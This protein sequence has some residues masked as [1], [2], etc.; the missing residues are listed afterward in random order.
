[1][2]LHGSQQTVKSILRSDYWRALVPYLTVEGR[3]GDGTL[4]ATH[5][6]LPAFN[7]QEKAAMHE[8]MLQDGYFDFQTGLIG[9]VNRLETAFV[10]LE[11]QGWSPIWCFVFDEVWSLA[12]ACESLLQQTIHPG[13]RLNHDFFAWLLPEDGSGKGWEPHRDRYSMPFDPDAVPPSQRGT[14]SMVSQGPLVQPELRCPLP[15]GAT[16]HS[17]EQS[18][19]PRR[20]PD[21]CWGSRDSPILTPEPPAGLLLARERSDESRWPPGV[22]S[23][24]P[25]GGG[26][27]G[28]PM[29][30][31]LW[32][33]VTAASPRSSCIYVVPAAW[34]THYWESGSEES[35][36]DPQDVRALPVP[37]GT[38]IV[39][40]GRLLHW[41][42]RAAGRGA[43]RRMSLAFAA[44]VP[45][46]EDPGL[47]L[48]VPREA[49]RAA[50]VPPS[51]EAGH[52][53]PASDADAGGARGG[54][55]RSRACADVDAA[56]DSEQDGP[57]G[58]RDEDLGAE[59]C[60]PEPAAAD[61]SVSAWARL[62]D[63]SSDA[64]PVK[65]RRLAGD[66]GPA[67]VDRGLEGGAT[68]VCSTPLGTDGAPG[69]RGRDGC[70]TLVGTVGARGDSGLAGCTTPVGTDGERGDRGLEGCATRLG[71][72]GER[73]DRG[74]AGWATCVGTDGARGDR[75]LEG[76]AARGGPDGARGDRGLEGCATCVGGRGETKMWCDCSH[77]CLGVQ[78]GREPPSLREESVSHVSGEGVLED[79]ALQGRMPSLRQRIHVIFTQLCTYSEREPVPPFV[80][81][82]LEE[83][84]GQGEEQPSSGAKKER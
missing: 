65:A 15:A 64:R 22:P 9:L 41:G 24:L 26:S 56:V 30:A 7:G 48:G 37:P 67:R 6:E 46:F 61:D 70:A 84:S 73:G 35:S 40:S 57:R 72:D 31:T 36:F 54:P 23:M 79:V 77:S 29:Y 3:R 55:P 75:G 43:P 78:T 63:R 32:L 62:G 2:I 34:D 17:S 28:L 18:R 47:R 51:Q 83:F 4:V 19:S 81:S 10:E 11:L 58:E 71:T 66:V 50:P 39:W 44:S 82:L 16:S 21:R 76:R 13:L 45:S 25:P 27:R 38:A 5:L 8:Q 74:L 80:W 52:R 68:G 1:M 49:D 12:H 53:G 59:G 20:G 33:A 69:D 42:S 60:V 14:M